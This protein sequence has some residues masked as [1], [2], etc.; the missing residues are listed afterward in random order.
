MYSW[1]AR[2]VTNGIIK[3]ASLNLNQTAQISTRLV[4]SRSTSGF[5]SLIANQAQKKEI[6]LGLRKE[7]LKYSTSKRWSPLYEK[8]T[9]GDRILSIEGNKCCSDCSNSD[10][11]YVSILNGAVYCPVCTGIHRQLGVNPHFVSLKGEIHV[12]NEDMQFYESMGNDHVNNIYEAS[13]DVVGAEKPTV[14]STRTE[15]SNYIREKYQDCSYSISRHDRP[16]TENVLHFVSNM[17]SRGRDVP[18]LR[19]K[20]IEKAGAT[21][22]EMMSEA[23]DAPYVLHIA[24]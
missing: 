13:L 19:E 17:K 14:S 8:V 11:Q 6:L 16:A 1:C 20:V 4:S 15:V 21:Y 10:V 22:G 23:F 7:A 3:K 18:D 5:I 2:S 12:S 24:E 9:D